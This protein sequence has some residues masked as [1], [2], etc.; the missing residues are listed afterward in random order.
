MNVIE[1]R[2]YA[3]LNAADPDCT[4]SAGPYPH[5]YLGCSQIALHVVSSTCHT[6]HDRLKALSDYLGAVKQKIDD[7]AAA[8][9]L[10]A[11]REAK[12]LHPATCVIPEGSGVWAGSPAPEGP[13]PEP[14]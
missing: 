5:V 7:T 2:L 10:A 1:A 11:I 8:E 6:R 3:E 14:F 9:L 12:A 4:I 13:E